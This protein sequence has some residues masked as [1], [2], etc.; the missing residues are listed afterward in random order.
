M[1]RLCFLISLVL[2]PMNFSINVRSRTIVTTL[3]CFASGLLLAGVLSHYLKDAFEAAP[4]IHRLFNV[5]AEKNF[6]SA[7][8][9]GL[10]LLSSVL[11][12]AITLAK[13]AAGD[14]FTWH[15]GGLSFV[16]AFLAVDEWLSFHE[17]LSDVIKSVLPANGIF[18]FAWI[19]V[20]MTFVGGLGLI[21]W[22]FLARLPRH[23][24]RLFL[25][26]AALFLSGAIG[27]EMIAGHYVATHK[28]W[29]YNIWLLLTTIEEGLEM[30]GTLLFIHSLFSYL[31]AFVEEV[32]ICMAK[33]PKSRPKSLA[34]PRKTT[35][36]TP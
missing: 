31:Q 29:N 30:F 2:L 1:Q 26:S 27:M 32:K 5:D 35:Q 10:L 28:G 13:K 19:L 15:W 23:Y 7:F 14:R 21:Y 22:S 17:K 11:L 9:T 34:I 16:F 18:Y 3:I 25:L 33:K 24:R 20:G 6:P 12:G 8:S 36:K 4:T